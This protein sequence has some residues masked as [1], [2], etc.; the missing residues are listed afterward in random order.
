MSTWLPRTSY[1]LFHD[2][3]VE[4]HYFCYEY[5]P[6]AIDHTIKDLVK[7]NDGDVRSGKVSPLQVRSFVDPVD[8]LY[9][10]LITKHFGAVANV[11]SFGSSFVPQ[12]Q[13]NLPTFQFFLISRKCLVTIVL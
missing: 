3:G 5:V 7:F 8:M 10:E 12:S 2:F 6:L 1:G 9:S 11:R 13:K 4:I